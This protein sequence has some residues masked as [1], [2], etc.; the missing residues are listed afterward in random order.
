[1]MIYPQA[2]GM[3]S[4]NGKQLNDT[5]TVVDRFVENSV[6][7]MVV[8]VVRA[9]KSLPLV[10]SAERSSML[11]ED[12]SSSVSTSSGSMLTCTMAL[13]FLFPAHAAATPP[14]PTCEAHV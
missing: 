14:W 7:V 6:E 4:P 10:S 8:K 1:M 11:C 5:E 3:V 9:M 2:G 12:D 13:F